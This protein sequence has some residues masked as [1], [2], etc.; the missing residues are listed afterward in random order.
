M[1]RERAYHAS[2]A[3]PSSGAVNAARTPAHESISVR[4]PSTISASCPCVR[5]RKSRRIG[6]TGSHP[7][8]SASADARRRYSSA[9]GGPAEETRGPRLEYGGMEREF[10]ALGHAGSEAYAG[11]E[12][13]PNPGV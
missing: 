9:N 1:P 11:L 4:S 7:A 13:F 12:T 5:P 6:S 8:A 2:I 3:V 10:V